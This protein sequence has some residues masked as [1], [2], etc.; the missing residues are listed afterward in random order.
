MGRNAL[1][2]KQVSKFQSLLTPN[3]NIRSQDLTLVFWLT[4]VSLCSTSS[5]PFPWTKN[6]I[7][8]GVPLH[9]SL[10]LENQVFSLLLIHGNALNL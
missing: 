2:Q 4:W 7:H 3:E 10:P 6:Q 9:V 8:N 5:T 1:S